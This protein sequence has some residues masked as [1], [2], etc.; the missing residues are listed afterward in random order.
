MSTEVRVT[1]EFYNRIILVEYTQVF[2]AV[3]GIALSMVINDIKYD[4]DM[5]GV[6]EDILRTYV[7]LASLTLVLAIYYRY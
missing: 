6:H 1:N 3:F 4:N 5:E 2:L 7:T